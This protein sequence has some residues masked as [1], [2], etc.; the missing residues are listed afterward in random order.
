MRENQIKKDVRTLS[1]LLGKWGK[2][3]PKAN[4]LN[5]N[6]SCSSKDSIITYSLNKSSPLIFK[7]IDLDRHSIPSGIENL[8]IDKKEFE[9][10]LNIVLAEHSLDDDYAVD[11]LTRLGVTIKVNGLYEKG[12]EDSKYVVCSWHLDRDAP[13]DS[14][15]CHP[16][17]HLN[18]GGDSMTSHALEE[19][20]FFGNL[21]L[22]PNPR[23]IHPPMDLILACD[24]IIRNFYKKTTHQ[25]ITNLPAYKDIF[26]RAA[27]RYWASYAFAFASKWNDTLSVSNLSHNKVIGL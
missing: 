14:T 19:P 6:F 11:P 15:Y 13:E 16:L 3:V 5:T 23:I 20:N 1:Q 22:M 24:F 10:H 4:I 27:N 26:N 9:V 12:E 18:F 17:Y 8:P 25:S 7:N 21:L 2:N